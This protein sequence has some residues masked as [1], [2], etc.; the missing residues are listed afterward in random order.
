MHGGGGV[1]HRGRVIPDLL[2]GLRLRGPNRKHGVPVSGRQQQL[3]P[4]IRVGTQI[5]DTSKRVATAAGVPN[6]NPC[7]THPVVQRGE[8]GRVGL[9][10]GG[11]L[12][13][14]RLEL[15]SALSSACPPTEGKASVRNGGG[16]S[17][18]GAQEERGRVGL[19]SRQYRT[20]QTVQDFSDSAGPMVD[21]VWSDPPRR[22][23]EPE[24]VEAARRLRVPGVE[25]GLERLLG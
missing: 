4:R 25:R 11:E 24:P 18:G 22:Q 21:C 14:R 19:K 13:N 5:W 10:R 1:G 2:V 15:A 7:A 20:F 9:N 17:G 3:V 23:R 6:S 8:V 16:L 12:P